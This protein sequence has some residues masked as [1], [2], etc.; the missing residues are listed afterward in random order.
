[1]FYF[2]YQFNSVLQF[3]F[4][5]LISSLPQSVQLILI[6]GEICARGYW[7]IP[8]DTSKEIL[9]DWFK[10][11]IEKAGLYDLKDTLYFPQDSGIQ[12]LL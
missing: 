3:F 7:N 12:I 9:S 6:Q 5:Y 2:H 11:K 8:D 4:F 10:K 1:M